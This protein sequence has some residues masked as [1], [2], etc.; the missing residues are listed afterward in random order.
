MNDDKQKKDIDFSNLDVEMLTYQGQSS[1]P[2]KTVGDVPEKFSTPVRHKSKKKA[3]KTMFFTLFGSLA[4]AA[5]VISTVVISKQVAVNRGKNSESNGDTVS[6]QIISTDYQD[7]T[8][9][10]EPVTSA[11]ETTESIETQAPVTEVPATPVKYVDITENDIFK[12]DLILV[13]YS[14]TDESGPK[15]D[16]VTIYSKKNKSYKVRDTRIS[17]REPVIYALNDMIAAFELDNGTNDV[18]VINASRTVDEQQEI[19]NSV[20]S[21]KGQEYAEENSEKPGHSEHQTGCA[22]DL[23]V[24]TDEGFTYRMSDKPEYEAWFKTNAAKYGFIL[25]YPEDKKPLIGVCCSNFHLRYVGEAHAEYMN[26]HGLCLEE[27][28]DKVR[29]FTWDGEHIKVSANDKDYEIYFVYYDSSDMR[30]PVPEN[31]TYTISGN[32]TD[33][34]IVTV[35]K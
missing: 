30:I 28:L 17:L 3:S 26:S 31:S 5:I 9:L 34:F 27:Y 16:I 24:Y 29:S 13:N 35:E 23:S 12:G 21:S 10:S 7:V 14:L 25:R 11:P 1:E 6:D 8:T 20:V 19:Y 4:V 32:N 22:V 2:V 33:G 18:L 15:D